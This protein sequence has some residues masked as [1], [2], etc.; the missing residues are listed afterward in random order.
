MLL[1]C[2]DDIQEKQ[3]K[4]IVARAETPLEKKN[5]KINIPTYFH[6]IGGGSSQYNMFYVFDNGCSFCVSKFIEVVH[7]FQSFKG[8]NFNNTRY[9]FIAINKDTSAIRY[10]L[11]KYNIIL[12]KNQY[13]LPDK[14]NEFVKLNSG[15]A[16]TNEVSYILTDSTYQTII[17]GDPFSDFNSR[18]T[19]DS[20]GILK[21]QAGK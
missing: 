15:I 12:S 4:L 10:Y 11:D 20:L 7:D 19:Y 1:S 3:A 2:H 21:R 5:I 9:F 18:D 14:N 16:A 13:L 17:L 8:N 6:G